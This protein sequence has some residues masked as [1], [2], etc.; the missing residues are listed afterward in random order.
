MLSSEDIDLR[1]TYLN[2]S[3]ATDANDSESNVI[4]NGTNED[5]GDEDPID[6]AVCQSTTQHFCTICQKKV[7][8]I[9]CS[10]QDPDSSNELSRVHKANDPRCSSLKLKCHICEKDEKSM[11]DS[12]MIN[13]SETSYKD[14]SEIS[15]ADDSSWKYVSC[16][17]CEENFENKAD[18]LLHIK[19][20]NLFPCGQC[21]YFCFDILDLNQHIADI[22]PQ[23]LYQKRRKQ[24]YMCFLNLFLYILYRY[25]IICNNLIV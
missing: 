13:H 10:E 7:C 12:H 4:D 15:E 24:E 2:N 5:D 21:A 17:R 6:C 9:F 20:C 11:F 22:H 25:N 23:N 19:T 14:V 8:V 1:E 3:E 18:L 16:D